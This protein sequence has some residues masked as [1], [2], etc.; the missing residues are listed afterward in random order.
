MNYSGV[1]AIFEVYTGDPPPAQNLEIIPTN[2]THIVQNKNQIQPINYKYPPKTKKTAKDKDN[3][4][5]LGNVY[6]KENKNCY[7]RSE[8]RMLVALGLDELV[9]IETEV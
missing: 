9:V 1:H 8:N 2:V 5:I 6:S 7:I 3:N 4:S